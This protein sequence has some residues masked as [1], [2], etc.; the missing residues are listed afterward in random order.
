MKVVSSVP[1]PKQAKAG[2]DPEARRR[3]HEGRGYSSECTMFVAKK[4]K[5]KA[6]SLL[7]IGLRRSFDQ[8]KRLCSCPELRRTKMRSC[9]EEKKMIIRGAHFTPHF[10]NLAL[11]EYRDTGFQILPPSNNIKFYYN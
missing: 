10:Y 6:S 9:L 3:G 5:K 1:G 2:S 11:S 8:V 4:K 7:T